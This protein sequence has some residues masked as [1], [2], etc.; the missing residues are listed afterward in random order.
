MK[1]RISKIRSQDN[2]VGQF[3]LFILCANQAF[4][5]FFINTMKE[6][7][8]TWACFVENIA[9]HSIFL[10]ILILEKVWQF[11]KDGLIK[12]WLFKYYCFSILFYNKFEIPACCLVNL[13]R[14]F[15]RGSSQVLV[16]FFK[17]KKMWHNLKLH[18]S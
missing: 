15:S 6:N 10:I 8:T 18:L 14:I 5:L 9:W 12:S 13:Y 1:T 16:S 2:G 17:V 11:N 7:V 3:I 4:S